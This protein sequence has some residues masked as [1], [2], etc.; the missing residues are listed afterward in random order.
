M[1]GW[2][3]IGE[4]ENKDNSVQLQLQ[5]PTGTELGK[6][7]NITILYIYLNILYLFRKIVP[8]VSVIVPTIDNHLM[9]KITISMNLIQ[10][11]SSW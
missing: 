4:L 1:A 11:T 2:V 9:Y 8:M 5:L 3:G 7:L 6:S 10:N